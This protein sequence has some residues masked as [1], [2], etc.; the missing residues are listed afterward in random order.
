M[1]GVEVAF[2][3]LAADPAPA[4]GGSAAIAAPQTQQGGTRCLLHCPG[5]PAPLGR[6]WGY[7]LTKPLFPTTFWGRTAPRDPSGLVQAGL[8]S[9]QMQLPGM[10]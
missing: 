4:G 6:V 5:L 3:W 1:N 8:G 2:S 10:R 9:Q 7:V